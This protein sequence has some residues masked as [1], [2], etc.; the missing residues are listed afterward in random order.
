MNSW[1]RVWPGSCYLGS[2]YGQDKLPGVEG[3]ENICNNV[4]VGGGRNIGLKADIAVLWLRSDVDGDI[5][6]KTIVFTFLQ[7]G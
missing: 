7:Y 2:K 1:Y 6:T 5:F 4:Q 3:V